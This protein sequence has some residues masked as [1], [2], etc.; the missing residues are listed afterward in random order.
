M[1]D[2]MTPSRLNCFTRLVIKPIKINRALPSYWIV[3]LADVLDNE[4]TDAGEFHAFDV[5]DH[6]TN[7]AGV[8]KKNINTDCY[9][10][11]TL[12]V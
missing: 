1:R 10:K 11:E 6:R 12:I 9:F 2:G 5:N 3:S 7:D 8:T 4:N